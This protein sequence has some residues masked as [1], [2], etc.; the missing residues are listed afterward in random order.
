MGGEER[1]KRYEQGQGVLL[2]LAIGSIR[3]TLPAGTSGVGRQDV[4][5]LYRLPGSP[6]LVFAEAA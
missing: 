2:V 6:W 5:R 3:A 1:F 4:R